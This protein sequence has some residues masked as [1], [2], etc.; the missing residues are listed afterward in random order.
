MITERPRITGLDA[1]RGTAAL[2]VV[3]GHITGGLFNRNVIEATPLNILISSHKAVL[4]FFLLSG[5][6]L[7]YQYDDHPQYT[8]RRFLIQRFFRLYIP[9]L[10][11]M[12]L[13]WLLFL[14]FAPTQ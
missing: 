12:L 3:L 7:V 8:Y 6:V 14:L 1:L 10:A 13:S 9:Y 11:A 2:S 4:F 5:F